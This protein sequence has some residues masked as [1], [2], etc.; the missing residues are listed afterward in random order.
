MFPAEAY[1][2]ETYPDMVGNGFMQSVYTVP[3]D[4]V[5]SDHAIHVGS[6]WGATMGHGLT[7]K[8]REL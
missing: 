5:A 4:D 2:E 8:K 1:P 6:L 3:A 7:F